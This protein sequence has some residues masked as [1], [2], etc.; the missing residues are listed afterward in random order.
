[1]KTNFDA[2]DKVV[3]ITGGASGIG[4]GLAMRFAADGAR[5]IIITDVNEAG[6]TETAEMC[7]GQAFMLDV[8]DEAATKSL[9]DSIIAE[10]G[11]I[12]LYFS[13]AGIGFGD[14]P[15]FT[16]YAQSSAQ[17]QKCW[18]VNVMA[19]F[20]AARAVLPAMRERGQGAF[21][22]TASAAGLLSQIGD[23]V[24]ATTKHAAIGFAEA[25]AIAHGDE[26][27]YVGVLCPQAVDTPMVQKA[28]DSNAAVIDGVMSVEDAINFTVDAMRDGKFMI[29][30]HPEVERYQMNKAKDYERW[31]GGMRKFRQ[32]LIAANGKPL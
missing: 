6:A 7:G 8:S 19:H 18:N 28:G 32:S 24:Y 31:V 9:V 23:A 14:L 3:V 25:M 16:V 15:D 4:R 5:A 30:P 27:I 20:H 29:R 10:H 22:L 11:Q 21:C 13:N 2:K 17:I 12:D 26:G 1:M